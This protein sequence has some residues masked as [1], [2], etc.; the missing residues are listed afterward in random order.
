MNDNITIKD[1]REIL[2]LVGRGSAPETAVG[3]LDPMVGR[4]V[5]VRSTQSGVWMGRLVAA[6]GH[7]VRLAGARRLWQWTGAT[8]CS[9]LAAFGP[10]GGKIGPAVSVGVHD[11]AEVLEAT[12]AAMGRLAAVPVWTV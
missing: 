10:G 11:A 4:D 2:A 8:E 7:D 1:I 12:E 6:N 9:G 5:V 3:L